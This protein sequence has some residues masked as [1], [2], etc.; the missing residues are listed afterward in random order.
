MNI[1]NDDCGVVSLHLFQNVIPTESYTRE[2]AMIDSIGL[3]HLTNMKKGNY[4]GETVGW[5]LEMKRSLGTC[6]LRRA[7]DIFIAEGERQIKPVDI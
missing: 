6:L 3:T 1:W 7:C 2:A 5:S 4:Y